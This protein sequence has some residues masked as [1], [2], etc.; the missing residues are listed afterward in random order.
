MVVSLSGPGPLYQQIYRAIRQS[1]RSGRLRP[2][3]RL[4]PTRELALQLGVSRNVVVT[5]YET[6]A[7]DGYLLSQVGA[8]TTV[9]SDLPDGT[10]ADLAEPALPPA[11]QG[12]ASP[13]PVHGVL[14]AYAER[15]LTVCREEEEPT[16]PLPYDFSYTRAN[17]ED[18]PGKIWRRIEARHLKSMPVCP[19]TSQGN[20]VLRTGIAA[21]IRRSRGVVCQTDQVLPMNG[22]QQALDLAA[23]V[24]VDPGGA[25]LME[26]PHYPAAREVFQALGARIVT[27]PVDRQG[28]VVDRLPAPDG[29]VQL[30]YLTPS[31]QFPTGAILSL[32]RR[33][34]LLNWAAAAGSYI[35]ED[36]SDGDYCYDGRPIEALQGM[37]GAERVLYMGTFA[38]SPVSS[39][40]MAYLVVPWACRPAFTTAKRLAEWHCSPIPQRVM[41]SFLAEGHFERYLR[42]SRARNHLRRDTLLDAVQRNFPGATEVLGQ[43]SGTHVFLRFPSIPA[44]F[45]VTIARV[46]A[47]RGV[48]I[49]PSSNCYIGRPQC[50]E[51]LL[52]YNGMPQTEIGPAIGLLRSA[53]TPWISDEAPE[54]YTGQYAGTQSEQRF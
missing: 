38:R 15:A 45:A 6:L 10:V 41:A 35:L 17:I 49:L 51:F 1:I 25:V 18:F 31:H 12:I 16:D 52:G 24:L 2:G 22:T 53:M 43:H 46:A 23:R 5:A 50:A 42:R 34:A 13:L 3:S 19:E 48:R 37:D 40:R 44:V 36:D 14:S 28:L 21:H 30:V 7:A 54:S 39:F 9:A 33:A 27:I 32:E 8:G 20:V 47:E 11:G 26:E 4:P 29:S